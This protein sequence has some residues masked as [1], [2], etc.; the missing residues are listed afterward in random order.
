[1]NQ[2]QER[3]KLIFVVGSQNTAYPGVGGISGRKEAQ[4]DLQ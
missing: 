3:K 4:K 1:M 2:V